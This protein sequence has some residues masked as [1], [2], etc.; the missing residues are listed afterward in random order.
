VLTR[1]PTAATCWRIDRFMR[2]IKAVLIGRV[3]QLCG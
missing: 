2:S 1:R 3:P